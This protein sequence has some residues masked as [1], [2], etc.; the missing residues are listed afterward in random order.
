MNE[1]KL[2]NNYF[3]K[4]TKN[5]PASKE[6]NDD[7]FFDKKNNLVVSVDTYNESVHFPNFNIFDCLLNP[8]FFVPLEYQYGQFNFS[9]IGKSIG[10]LSAIKVIFIND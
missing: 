5:N 6:L 10:Y 7:V 3:L 1:F 9:E 2:I 4:L 8:K